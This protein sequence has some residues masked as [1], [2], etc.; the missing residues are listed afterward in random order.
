MKHDLPDMEDRPQDLHNNIVEP[1]AELDQ[2][3][4]EEL[5][6]DCHTFIDA[7][8]ERQQNK[9]VKT[10]GLALLKRLH[11]VISWSRIH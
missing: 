1:A 5:L 6:Q 4:L 9:W 8:L 10:D 3:D 2:E 7:L 11:E